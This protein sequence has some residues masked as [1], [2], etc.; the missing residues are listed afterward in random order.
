MVKPRD[1]K[2][3]YARRIARAL[4]QGK[5]R[6]QARGHKAHEHIERAERER[7]RNEGLTNAQIRTVFDWAVRR[8]FEIHDDF[9]DPLE[10]VEETKSRGYDWFKLYRRSWEAWR[11]SYLRRQARGLPYEAQRSVESMEAE[12]EGVPE[13][14]WL[15]YH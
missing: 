10:L 3:E 15:Y 5:T 6:Q 1:F 13:I 7:E 9:S 14:S 2:A 11:R 4:A 8:N 12:V